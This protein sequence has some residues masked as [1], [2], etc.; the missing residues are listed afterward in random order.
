MADG[1]QAALAVLI[2]TGLI[3]TVAAILEY[4]VHGDGM[5][6]AD[7]GIGVIQ[8]DG[9]AVIGSCAGALIILYAELLECQAEGQYLTETL[10]RYPLGCGLS[11]TYMHTSLFAGEHSYKRADQDKHQCYVKEENGR[12][13]YGLAFYQINNA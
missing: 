2:I 6:G 3:E 7:S 11:L 13:L 8:T 1:E 5:G 9:A 4:V 12:L 10:I